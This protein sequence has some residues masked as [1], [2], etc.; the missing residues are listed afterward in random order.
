MASH[1]WKDFEDQKKKNEY[2]A[3]IYSPSYCF[4]PSWNTKEH[5]ECGF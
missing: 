2:V 4:K 3:I 1:S 5:N